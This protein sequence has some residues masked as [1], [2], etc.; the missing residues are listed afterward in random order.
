MHRFDAAELAQTQYVYFPLHKETDLP[1]NFQAAGW[2]DQRNT[3]RLLASVMPS[4]YRF[5]VREHRH[6][7]GFR[8]TRYY[9]ELAQLPNVTFIDAYNSQFK[10]LQNADLIVTE[11]GS[12]GWEGLLLG[13]KVLTLAPT[14]YDGAGFAKRV[15]APVQLGAAI[16]E[17]LQAP[18][19]TDQAAYDEG[20]GCMVDAEYET[21]FDANGREAA[22]RQFANMLLPLRPN[23]SHAH[24]RTS[25]N[26]VLKTP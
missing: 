6:N 13:R 3:I 4:G 12:S 11:N 2:F 23:L 17:A 22:L 26:G 21:T 19:V 24:Q 1:L 8:P 14:F 9:R 15:E 10:Y 7:Y 25:V 5:L 18:A 20:L 16:M